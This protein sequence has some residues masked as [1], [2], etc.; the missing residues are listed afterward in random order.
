MVGRTEVVAAVAAAVKTWGGHRR[1]PTDADL[2]GK[3]SLTGCTLEVL[4]LADIIPAG[5]PRAVLQ[6]RAAPGSPL[7]Q[8]LD[9]DAARLL[10]VACELDAASARWSR[11]LLRLRT[12]SADIAAVPDREDIRAR[13]S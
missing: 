2:L 4:G 9:R 12:V 3:E 10:D 5:S 1:T 6:F 7:A 13:R 11:I 8:I